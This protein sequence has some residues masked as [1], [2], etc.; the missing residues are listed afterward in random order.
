MRLKDIAYIN[1][2]TL[3]ENTAGSYQFRYI[4]ISSISSEGEISLDEY[5]SFSDAPS[6]ARRIVRQGDILVST[7]RTYL[8]AIAPIDFEA[9]DI[10]ASTGFAVCTPKKVVNSQYLSY[11][12]KNNSVINDIC[13]EST[14]VSYPAITASR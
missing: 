5:Y 6:R 8:R 9:K 11:A 3:P 1:V 7:V 10:I 12:I 4:D 14:G 2:S 13:K